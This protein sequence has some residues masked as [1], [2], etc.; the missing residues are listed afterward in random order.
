MGYT[1]SMKTAV[2]I[3]DDVFEEAE[4]LAMELQ[5]SRSQ[6]YSRALQ[7]FVARHAPDRMTEAMNRVIDEV[8]SEI[9][10]FSQRASRRVLERV[11]W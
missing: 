5:T 9:E 7:E 10:E 3:P 2:S 11:E 8:G 6:L 1:W 4:R